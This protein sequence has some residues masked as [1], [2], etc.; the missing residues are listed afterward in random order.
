[1]K[2][3]DFREMSADEL[4]VREHVLRE[5]LFRLRFKNGIRQL[6]NTAKLKNLRKDIARLETVRNE[7]Q[8]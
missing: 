8:G 6:E 4:T 5:E 1:M 7:K 3:K 2:A